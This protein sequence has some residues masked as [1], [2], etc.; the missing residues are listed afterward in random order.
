MINWSNTKL[1]VW[2]GITIVVQTLLLL[3]APIVTIIVIYGDEDMINYSMFAIVIGII[4][5]VLFIKKMK[6]IIDNMARSTKKNIL[7]MCYKL[8]FMGC[9]GFCLYELKT[10]FEVAF[11]TIAICLIYVV[12]SIILDGLFFKKIEEIYHYNAL[13]NEKLNVERRVGYVR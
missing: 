5:I 13:A 2:Y 6:K 1:N 8:L 3:V 4:F 9:A 10:N 7:V 12:A 11:M